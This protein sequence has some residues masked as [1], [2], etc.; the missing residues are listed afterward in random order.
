MKTYIVKLSMTVR[1]EVEA[2]NKEE[3]KDTAIEVFNEDFNNPAKDDI[4][5]DIDEITQINPETGEPL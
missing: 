4:I 2:E 5:P 3:A 1:V